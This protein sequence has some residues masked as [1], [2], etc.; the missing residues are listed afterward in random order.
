[1][2]DFTSLKVKKK[3]RSL[4]FFLN[5]IFFFIVQ[6][7]KSLNKKNFSKKIKNL[8]KNNSEYSFFYFLKKSVM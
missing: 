8:R 5:V 6:V 2:L 4:F 3:Y 1:M 7:K